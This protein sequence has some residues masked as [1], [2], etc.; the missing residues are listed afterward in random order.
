MSLETVQAVGPFGMDAPQPV[1]H[2]EQAL[3]LNAHG[4]ALAGKTVRRKGTSAPIGPRQF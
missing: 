1:V 3:D 4:A 2:W